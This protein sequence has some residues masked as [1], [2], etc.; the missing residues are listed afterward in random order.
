M[1]QGGKI[2]G[3]NA[4]KWIEMN[5]PKYSEMDVILMKNR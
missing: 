5:K 3:G 2:A 4:E 1:K